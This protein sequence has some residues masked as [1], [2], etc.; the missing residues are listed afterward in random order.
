[1]KLSRK[2][3]V[4]AAIPCLMAADGGSDD[5]PKPIPTGE[6][7]CRVSSEYKFRKCRVTD[8]GKYR[9][10]DLYE[11][12]HLL[13][14]QGQLY[15]SDFVGKSKIVYFEARLNED[16]PYICTVSDPAAREACKAQTVLIPLQKKGNTWTGTFG[17]KHYW[18]D[19]VGDGA[20]RRKSGYVVTI[21]PL[22][23]TLKLNAA[24]KPTTA[25]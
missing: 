16:N 12:G 19:Y 23:F 5:L 10:L 21:E 22:T 9:H 4:L 18:D 7:T 11:E 24:A 15:P 17:A 14:L 20:Q 8:E 3:A 13:Q 1:M 2:L 6:F 25:D